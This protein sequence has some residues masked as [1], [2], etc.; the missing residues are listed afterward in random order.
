ME[1]PQ[2]ALDSPP[3]GASFPVVMQHFMPGNY[4]CL[5]AC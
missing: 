4:R 5:S 1:L 3:D 2:Y